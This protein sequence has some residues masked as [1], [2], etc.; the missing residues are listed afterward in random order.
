MCDYACKHFKLEESTMEAT[1]YPGLDQHRAEHR[2]FLEKTT[3]FCLERTLSQSL[4]T[5]DV[6]QYLRDWFSVHL[7]N[8]DRKMD[9]YL[10]ETIGTTMPH[11]PF[12]ET[13]K[14]NQ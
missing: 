14:P 4:S 13:K 5:A 8:E 11:G 6:I 9:L 7:E 12:G 3:E 1:N 10:R 2:K